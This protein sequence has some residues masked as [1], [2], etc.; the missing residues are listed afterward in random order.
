M[1]PQK[2]RIQMVITIQIIGAVLWFLISIFLIEVKKMVLSSI[3][4][5]IAIIALIAWLEWKLIVCPNCKRHSL[6]FANRIVD[7]YF[8]YEYNQNRRQ[9]PPEC[10]HCGKTYG[11]YSNR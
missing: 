3:L 5:A 6:F 7:Y 10:P 8:R 11:E 2:E 4:L 1:Y 9:K